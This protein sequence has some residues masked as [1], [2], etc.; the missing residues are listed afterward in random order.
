MRPPRAGINFVQDIPP[1]AKAAF[2][3]G[4][5]LAR[6]NRI[7]EAIAAYQD[8]IKIFP[9]YFNAHLILA[10]ELAKQNKLQD[11]I[12]SLDAAR[13]VNP[14]DDRVY[15]LFARVMMQQRKFSVA[16]RIYAEAA[17]LNP[18]EPQYQ[19]S[20]AIALIEQAGLIDVGQKSADEDRRFALDE[21]ERILLQALKQNDRLADAHLQLA[22]VYERKGQKKQAADQLE[23]YLRKSPGAKNADQIKLAI[24]T[25][26][27]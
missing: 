25:L 5:K 11:A 23:L 6:E 18:A 20:Q 2:E 27:Q 8:A 26:R 13:S 14:K 24:K 10:S 22:R 15:D 1:Q 7:P 21:A 9:T 17:R 4:L 12:S 16:A 19:I 3:T